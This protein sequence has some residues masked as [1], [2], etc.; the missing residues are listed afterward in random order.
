MPTGNSAI[1][2]AIFGIF[3]VDM[4]IQF[5]SAY[6]DEN[7]EVIDKRKPIIRNYLTTWFFIDLI[8]LIP[9]EVIGGSES[10]KTA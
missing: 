8:A 7:Y 6:L 1:N 5:N 9:Y 10:G 3:A 4:L 2:W